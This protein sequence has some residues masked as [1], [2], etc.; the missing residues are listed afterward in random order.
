ML[1]RSEEV[2]KAVLRGRAGLGERTR[3]AA[4]LLFMGPTGV[5]KTEL[6]KALADCVYGSRDALVRID[7]TEYMEP[8]SVTRLIGAPPGYIGYEEG[9]TLTEKVRRRPYSVILFDEIEKAHPD[10]F[11]ML[12][13]ILDDGMLTDSQG[14]RVDFKNCII[15]MTSNVGAK[16]ISGSGNALGFSTERGDVPNHDRVREL[17]TGELKNTFRPEFLNRI[18]DITVF[19]SLEKSDISEIARRLLETLSG[20][21]GQ[22]G[23]ALTFDESAVE[24]TADAGFDP[25]YGARPLKRVIQREIEDKLSEQ[26]LEGKVTVGKKYLCKAENGEFVFVER[27]EPESAENE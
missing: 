25:V 22:L 12:L 21:V 7:M 16:L 5:G 3:P 11:N 2:S 24:K 6:C 13:Q 18:D 27:N 10:V 20:R 14:R 1:F 19:H 17:V 26:M 9:G 15:I 8:N 23:I 4:S